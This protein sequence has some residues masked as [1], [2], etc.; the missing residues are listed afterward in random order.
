M[1][2][3]PNQIAVV[4]MQELWYDENRWEIHLPKGEYR[5]CMAT[6]LIGDSGFPTTVVKSRP[7]RAGRH[8]VALEQVRSENGWRITASWDGVDRLSVDEPKDWDESTGASSSGAIG[9]ETTQ[10]PA[11]QPVELIRR[12][13]FRKSAKGMPIGRAEP[14]NGILLWI[15]PATGTRASR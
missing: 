2:K 5:L 15:E 3:E 6:R 4:K 14:E 10:S 8:Q 13:F 9:S 7:I 12:R 11:D 1:I